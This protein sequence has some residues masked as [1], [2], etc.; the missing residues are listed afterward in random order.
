MD[1]PHIVGLLASHTTA[2]GTFVMMEPCDSGD[3]KIHLK[4]SGPLP[5][6]RVQALLVQLAAALQYMRRHGIVHRDL[7]PE[8]LL[9]HSSANGPSPPSRSRSSSPR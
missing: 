5:E 1:H 4:Q 9:L 6:A 7:K 2:W 8:N 3:L